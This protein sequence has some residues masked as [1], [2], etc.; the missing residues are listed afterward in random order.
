MQ[1]SVD[2]FRVMKQCIG[3]LHLVIGMKH[4]PRAVFAVPLFDS[5]VNVPF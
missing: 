5:I 2:D 4:H 1:I 3:R